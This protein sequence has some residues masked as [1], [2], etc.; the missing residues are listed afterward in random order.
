MTG[1]A[2]APAPVAFVHWG[3]DWIRGSEQCLLDLVAR[4]PRDRYRPVVVCNAPSLA[5]AAS[6]L[7]AEVA[8]VAEW[9]PGPVPSAGARARVHDLLA[10]RGVRLVHSNVPYAMPTLVPVAR[11]LRVPL[12]VHLHQSI[13]DRPFRLYALLHQA[14]VAVGVAGHVVA[15]LR[16]DGMPADRLRVILNA[17]DAERIEA[18][19]A[20]GLRASLGI[21]DAAAVAVSVGSLIHRKGHDVTVAAVAE[22]RRAGVDLHLLLGGDGE[23]AS[24]L[25]ALAAELGVA[26]YVHFLGYRP[27]PGAVM[28]AGDLLV[29]S[30]RDEALNLN[31]LEAQWLGVAVVASDIPA[32][33]E[34]VEDGVTGAVV[35][36]EDPAALARAVSDLTADPARRAR[37]AAAGRRVARER[38]TMARYVAEFDGLYRGLLARP[39]ADFGWVRGSSWPRA[40]TPWLAGAVRRRIGLP[41]GGS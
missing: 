25:R 19:D 27:D 7:G 10:E 21:P 3:A 34:A 33:R 22:A 29:S 4:L 13:E 5:G 20:S 41:H 30:A 36:L 23:A 1:P 32:H 14:T 38:Y 31:V 18:G 15:P 28:R 35:P 2:S 6:A 37:L 40:Y 24:E 8:H 26:P 11:R 12:V 9:E 17:V 16:A 39:R